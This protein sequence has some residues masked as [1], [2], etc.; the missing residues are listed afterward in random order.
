MSFFGG[1]GATTAYYHFIFGPAAPET[2][3]EIDELPV[4]ASMIR[5]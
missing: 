4:R 2:I 5:R 1:D 3:P